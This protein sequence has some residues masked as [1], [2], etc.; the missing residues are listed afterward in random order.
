[1]PNPDPTKIRYR[2][3]IKVKGP[4]DV[5]LG[6]ISS[7]SLTSLYR[8]QP[9]IS[10]ALIIHFDTDEIGSG[11]KF[12]LIPEVGLHLASMP[13]SSSYPAPFRTRIF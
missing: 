2:G 8:Y 1:M 5:V 3:I 13:S 9:D 7:S 11:S 12:N 6:Y 4:E 10:K